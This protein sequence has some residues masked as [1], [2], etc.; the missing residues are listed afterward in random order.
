MEA[1]KLFDDGSRTWL[2][3]GR[4]E[5]KPERVIDTNEYLIVHDGRA[6]LLDPG[7]PEVFPPVIAAVS[8]Y[9]HVEDIEAIFGSHQDPDVISSLP[10]W[11]TLSPDARIYVP[12]IWTGFLAHFARDVE[13]VA[14]P[15]GGMRIP[16]NGADDLVAIPAHYLHSSSNF[17]LYDERAK[18]LFSG[19][20]GAA[21]VPEDAPP[22]VENFDAHIRYMEGFHRRWM[23][24]DR[25]K[26]VW[27]D[28]VRRLDVE[29][30]CPQHGSIFR[31]PDVARFLDWFEQ[32]EVGAAVNTVAVA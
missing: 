16:L 24:S 15:D 1:V 6:L 11:G 28:R 30:M 7:G 19:D 22:F 14:I 10:L 18:I 8:R 2:Y 31:G 3:F 29:M 27:I 21:L 13:A 17:S 20:I 25:A 23:P 5:T 12:Q 26:K 32:L 9:V 4:D